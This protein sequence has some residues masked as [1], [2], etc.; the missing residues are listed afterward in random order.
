MVAHIASE[1]RFK[2]FSIRQVE[3]ITAHK[4]LVGNVLERVLHDQL[5]LIGTEYDADRFCVT[6]SVHFLPIVV[7]IEVHLADVLVLDFTALE[8]DQYK[9]FQNAMVKNEIDFVSP[10]TDHQ[11]LLSPDI[12][13]TFSE[14]KEEK[15]QIIDQ[16]LFQI[17]F[18]V[19]RKLRQSGE[20]K[21]IRLTQNVFRA[22]NAPEP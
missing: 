12:G 14:F 15:A 11:L 18:C 6:L 4:N 8:V 13:E 2:L 3:L 22:L 20:F 7:Q 10:A 19:N 21:N 5:V 17:T 16:C 9:A 1:F